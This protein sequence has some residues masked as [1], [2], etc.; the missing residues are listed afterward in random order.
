MTF[1]EDGTRFDPAC[2]FHGRDGSMVVKFRG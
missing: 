2:P 1:I